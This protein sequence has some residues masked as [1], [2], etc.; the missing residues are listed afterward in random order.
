MKV[1]LT[2]AS[3]FLGSAIC[4]AFLKAGN[5]VIVTKRA[6][7]DF[8]RLIEYQDQLE[9]LNIDDAEFAYFF[10]ANRDIDAIVHA[11]TDYGRNL[12]SPTSVFWANEALPMKLL[13]AAVRSRIGLFVNFDTFFNSENSNY[14]YL[15][16][17]VL[18]K[19]HFQEWGRLVGSAG[20]INFV[21]MK[22]FHV[23]GSGDSQEKFVTTMIQRCMS[24]LPIDLT[25]GEQRRDFIYVDDVVDAAM[26]IVDSEVLRG[27][28]YKNFDVGT[29]KSTS[30]KE[31]M[32]TLKHLTNSNSLLNFGA[33]NSRSGE[34]DNSFA[35]T[36]PLG[37]VGWVAKVDLISGLK[38]LV[39]EFATRVSK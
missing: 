39:A 4:R 36:F 12:D 20:M 21:N 27:A 31:F 19:R 24:G 23:Y 2:G 5:K 32:F 25:S 14:D 35:D 16:P 7:T 11:A 13:Q 37:K 18:S 17:Y 6:T 1:L 28:G 38:K 30:I 22:L 34:F 29:G 3:G 15:G 9:F 10:D 8:N 33:L 26:R